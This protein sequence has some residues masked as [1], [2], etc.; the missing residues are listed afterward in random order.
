MLGGGAGTP[1][2]AAGMAVLA[3]ILRRQSGQHASSPSPSLGMIRSS[4][5]LLASVIAAPGSARFVDAGWNAPSS[6][7]IKS[8]KDT[9]AVESTKI[10]RL[11]ALAADSCRHRLLEQKSPNKPYYLPR[12]MWV[13]GDGNRGENK[14]V[15]ED[16]KGGKGDSA[17]ERKSTLAVLRRIFRVGSVREN[18]RE[19]Q[20]VLGAVLQALR[21]QENGSRGGGDDS[22][23][24]DDVVKI[25]FLAPMCIANPR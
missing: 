11:L 7:Q 15:E 16:D 5:N 12:W 25:R 9:R 2:R 24:N 3:Q 4:V 19:R 1:H 22:G 23:D 14:G 10:S 8:P 17:K 13:A 6:Y 18:E 20:F 21:Q